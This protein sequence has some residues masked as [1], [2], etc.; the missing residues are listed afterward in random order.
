MSTIIRTATVDTPTGALCVAV[1]VDDDAAG[2]RV[3]VAAF[4]DHFDRVAAK[5][6]LRF[7]GA[8]WVEAGTDAADAVR[9]YLRGDLDAVDGVV[10]D[11]TGTP[12]QEKVWAALRTIPA[13]ETR[14]YGQVAAAIDSPGAVRAVG[15]AN[16]ANP[17]WVLVPCHRVVRSDGTVGGYGGGAHRKEWLLQHER[18]AT[19]RSGTK[20]TSPSGRGDGRSALDPS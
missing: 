11:A 12:F 18:S 20:V 19:A 14:S 1:A 9:R 10:V 16:G 2:E 5:V 7:A 15:A 4:A 8:E 3:V 6:R 13:G 17:V